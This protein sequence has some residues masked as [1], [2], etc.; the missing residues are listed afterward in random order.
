[1]NNSIPY[2]N[3]ISRE[4]IVKRIKQ[5]A[6]ETFSFEDFVKNDKR[7]VGVEQSLAKAS[8]KGRASHY[9]CARQYRP[10]IRKGSPLRMAKVRRHRK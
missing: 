2:Y 8:A 7:D 10:V 3:A 4:S 9:A 1:M 6:G 5:Y